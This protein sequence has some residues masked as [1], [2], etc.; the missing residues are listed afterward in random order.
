MGVYVD[1]RFL[2]DPTHLG[3]DDLTARGVQS[4]RL[5]L[6]VSGKFRSTPTRGSP[7]QTY[8]MKVS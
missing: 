3:D 7:L 4:D 8:I 5:S 1:N 2:T 6:I